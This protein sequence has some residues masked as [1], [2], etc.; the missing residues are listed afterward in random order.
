MVI[1]DDLG[2]SDVGS[3]PTGAVN[4]EMSISKVKNLKNK[5]QFKGEENY[6]KRNYDS[7]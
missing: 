1:T 4:S 2:S 6:D 3:I 7:T 5:I